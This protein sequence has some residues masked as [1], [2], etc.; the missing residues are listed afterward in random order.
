MEQEATPTPEPKPL[1]GFSARRFRGLIFLLLAIALVYVVLFEGDPP[2]TFSDV[3]VRFPPEPNIA[4]E[5]PAFDVPDQPAAE[6][7]E[8][9]AEA[10]PASRPNE[11]IIEAVPAKPSVAPEPQAAQEPAGDNAA[12]PAEAEEAADAADIQPVAEADAEDAEPE[13]NAGRDAD[14]QET[15]AVAVADG[16]TEIRVVALLDR[17]EA[18][19]RARRLQELLAVPAHIKEVT[20]N[21]ETL[22]RVWLG[23]FTGPAAIA[24]LAEFRRKDADNSLNSRKAYLAAR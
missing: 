2:P 14:V 8:A 5:E 15:A 12:Q 10:G 3:T 4:F 7:P 9:E 13:A 21:G 18:E 6:R 17:A 19:K 23:P 22:H 20:I 24:A 1:Y 16:D 11:A